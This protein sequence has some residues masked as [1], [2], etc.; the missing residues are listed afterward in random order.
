M[1]TYPQARQAVQAPQ[2][3]TT[4]VNTSNAKVRY[5][6]RT[7][8]EYVNQYELHRKL[9][10]GAYGKVY[11]TVDTQV[12]PPRKAALKIMN[13][14][15]LMKKKGNIQAAKRVLEGFFFLFQFSF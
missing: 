12:N 8:R 3:Q 5:N 1:Q 7:G 13:Y 2:Q 11:L 15:L 14:K 10:E 4:V 9:G 6:R